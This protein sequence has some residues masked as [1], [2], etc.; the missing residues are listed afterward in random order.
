MDAPPGS[1][2]FLADFSVWLRDCRQFHKILGSDLINL[3]ELR[4]GQI[5]PS[6]QPANATKPNFQT[7]QNFQLS[8]MHM[9]FRTCAVF[10]EEPTVK[11]SL[12][13]SS[14]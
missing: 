3:R 4:I 5:C 9:M 11:I 2:G 7:L 6:L 14:A 10:Q 8:Y 1:S 12:E 13:G